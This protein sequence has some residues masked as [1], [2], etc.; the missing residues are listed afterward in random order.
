[1]SIE[2]QRREYRHGRL[3]R[4][5]LRDC[6]FDQFQLW[7]DQTVDSEIS[8]PTAMSLATVSAGGRPWQR[9]V[10]LKRFDRRG[11]VFYTNLGSRKA[12]EIAAN[13]QVCLLFPW[14]PMDRQVIVGG[15]ASPLAREDVRQ[16]FA[17]R[18]RGSQLAA[19]A[20][21][22]S[23]AIDNRQALEDRY[24]QMQD[25]FADTEVPL[26]DFWGGY[27]V[28]PDSFEFWQ[29]G[30]TRLHDRFTYILDDAGAWQINRLS[31]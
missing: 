18:P 1:M 4:A 24:R 31:P 10:L 21:R 16:Y 6:P 20:S 11:F 8:D 26:P 19:W 12:L 14:M 17:T 25:K 27:L 29:G 9:V 3:T 5:S 15:I 2:H 30:E 28:Q 13:P 22:Q 23:S 7:L